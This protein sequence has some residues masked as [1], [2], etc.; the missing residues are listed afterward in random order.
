M[1]GPCVTCYGVIRTIGVDGESA[2]EEQDTHLGRTYP[3][4]SIITTG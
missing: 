4:H 1:K 2:R 3:K